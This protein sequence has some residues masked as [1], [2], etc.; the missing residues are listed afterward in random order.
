MWGFCWF[1]FFLV[2]LYAV[3][4][5]NRLSKDIL[6]EAF[7]LSVSEGAMGVVISSSGN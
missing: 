3:W 6:P 7:L 1:G 5:L 4:T 2:F